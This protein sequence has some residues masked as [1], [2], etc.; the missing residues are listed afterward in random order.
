MVAH[1]CSVE[2]GSGS[3]PG[4]SDGGHSLDDAGPT[5]RLYRGQPLDEHTNHDM[6]LEAVANDA[7]EDLGDGTKTRGTNWINPDQ[8][9]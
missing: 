2:N 3:G 6:A 1:T 7:A 8:E 5:L 4:R 9:P